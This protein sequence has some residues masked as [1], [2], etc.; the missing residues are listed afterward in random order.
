MNPTQQPI[1]TSKAPAALGPYSQGTLVPGLGLVFTSGQLGIDP[2]TGQLVAGGVE[3]EFRQVLS[4]LR[5]ILEAAGSGFDRVVRST[6]YLTDLADFGT[7]NALYGEQIGSPPPA[8]STVGVASL[9]KGARV[10]MDI[11]ATS[12]RKGL[13]EGLGQPAH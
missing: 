8:R 7:V 5:A 11:V 4:N 2:A 10:E 12:S 9:P 3:A 6:L 13:P 1:S